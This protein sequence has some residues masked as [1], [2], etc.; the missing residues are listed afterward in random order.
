MDKVLSD[1]GDHSETGIVLLVGGLQMRERWYSH[2]VGREKKGKK[3]HHF[4]RMCPEKFINL[5]CILLWNM[6]TIFPWETHCGIYWS[7]S[8]KTKTILP[9]NILKV[10]K[11]LFVEWDNKR[12]Q[13][14]RSQVTFTYRLREIRQWILS[15]LTSNRKTLH[16]RKKNSPRSIY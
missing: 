7:W 15:P 13:P 16:S 2:C 1:D 4:Q 10:K 14:K 3:K 11:L 12:L 8:T 6:N 5:I 9:T